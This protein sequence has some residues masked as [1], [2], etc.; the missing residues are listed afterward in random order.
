MVE[1]LS[2][3]GS[4]IKLHFCNVS[5]NIDRNFNEFLASCPTVTVWS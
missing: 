3:F 2:D 5:N 4:Q 1:V